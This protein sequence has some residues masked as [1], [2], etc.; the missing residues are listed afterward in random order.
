M[1]SK[2]GKEKGKDFESQYLGALVHHD[3]LPGDLVG[4]DLPGVVGATHLDDAQRQLQF[5]LRLLLDVTQRDD[6]VGHIL[7]Q[8]VPAGQRV[9]GQAPAAPAR[10]PAEAGSPGWR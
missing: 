1:T 3:A 2:K 7:C 5:A 8:S 6:A 4:R 10:T 9:A